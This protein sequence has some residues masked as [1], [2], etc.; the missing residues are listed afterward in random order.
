M[1]RDFI[2]EDSSVSVSEQARLDSLIRALGIVTRGREGNSLTL[3][4]T[5][6]LHS[7]KI[8]RKLAEGIQR[9]SSRHHKVL[10]LCPGFKKQKSEKPEWK[11]FLDD[12][13]PEDQNICSI[14]RYRHL[15]RFHLMRR[16]LFNSGS[17]VLEIEASDSHW[18]ILKSIDK[19]RCQMSGR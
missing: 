15:S 17:S 14:V 8:L 18:K 2:T 5:E 10:F 16:A 9:T 3:V 11:S 12:Q 4:I 6:V 1:Q 7:A 19:V 13:T